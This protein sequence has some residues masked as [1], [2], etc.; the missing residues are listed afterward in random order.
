ML[1]SPDA[2]LLFPK[3]VMESSKDIFN[4]ILCSKLSGFTVRIRFNDFAEANVNST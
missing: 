1:S 3:Y 4:A 2:Y